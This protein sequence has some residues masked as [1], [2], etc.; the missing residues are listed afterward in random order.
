MKCELAR[1]ALGSCMCL[2]GSSSPPMRADFHVREAASRVPKSCAKIWFPHLDTASYSLHLPTTSP[3]KMSSKNKL[4]KVSAPH[5]TL[6]PS[7]QPQTDSVCLVPSIQQ[8]KNAVAASSPS[9]S[10]SSSPKPSSSS[11]FTPLTVSQANTLQTLH[12]EHL[13]RL[14]S[15]TLP[16][17][18][19]SHSR[20]FSTSHEPKCRHLTRCGPPRSCR[21]CGIGDV[22]GLKMSNL[23]RTR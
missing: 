5:H 6:L 22:P 15:I 1:A 9:S 13:A 10:R 7:L 21:L 19:S 8:F 4:S 20:R 16:H 2:E 17:L 18:A 11:T 3:D 23:N 12:Q 14:A